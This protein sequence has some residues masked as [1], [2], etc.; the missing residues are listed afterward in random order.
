M[1]RFTKFANFMGHKELENHYNDKKL[2]GY[3][4]T[5][6]NPVVENFITYCQ[7]KCYKLFFCEKGV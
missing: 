5:F 2:K 4:R 7:S 6:H 3:L 1:N